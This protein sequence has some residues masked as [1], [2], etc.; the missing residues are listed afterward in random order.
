M[1][2]D[3]MN[4]RA[5]LDML[6]DYLDGGLT[7]ES[8]VAFKRHADA[9]VKCTRLLA[10][11][12][13]GEAPPEAAPDLT[14]AVLA[15]T[16][17]PSCGLVER[18]L[19][20]REAAHREMEYD[21][22]V[23]QHLAHCPRCRG[24]EAVLNWVVPLL[25]DMAEAMPDRAFVADVVRATSRAPG[26]RA[27]KVTMGEWWERIVSVP[28]FE[29]QA[30]YVGAALL[31]V[32]GV[33]PLVPI[34]GAATLLS[35]AGAQVSELVSRAD[36]AY[37]RFG[38]S[39][40]PVWESSGARLIAPIESMIQGVTLRYRAAEMAAD[41]LWSGIECF[42]GAVRHGDFLS[43][44]AHARGMSSSMESL[45]RAIRHGGV[46]TSGTGAGENAERSR[47]ATT[48]RSSHPTLA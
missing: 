24:M 25:P 3:K 38:E 35:T 34:R 31:L 22:L 40:T 20:A 36:E 42:A 11:V 2:R 43:A 8:Q 19:A 37:A 30:A 15:R 29:L 28:L 23:R 17:G 9:C 48:D 44:S 46:S 47:T 18:T 21:A 39:L 41:S 45:W 1:T 10:T 5:W 12:R 16:S 6:A 7:P 4:C 27:W 32:V 26:R 14:E 33:S 13:D